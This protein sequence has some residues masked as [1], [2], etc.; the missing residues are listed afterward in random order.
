LGRLGGSVGWATAFGSGRDSGVPGLGPASGFLLSGES[1][2][3]SDPLS[4]CVLSLNLS[5]SDK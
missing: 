5:L 4:S 2:S 3:A 1:A